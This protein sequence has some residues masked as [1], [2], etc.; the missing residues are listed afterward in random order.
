MD[1]MSCILVAFKIPIYFTGRF[2]SAPSRDLKQ[3]MKFSTVVN[4]VDY[5]K[6]ADDFKVRVKHLPTNTE[7]EEKF[8]H[9]IV[10]SGTFSYG[11]KPYI[12]GIEQ[13]K[14]PV[15]HSQ[16]VKHMEEFKGRRI[17]LIGARWSAE[18]FALQAYKYGAKSVVISWRTAPHGHDWFEFPA[19]ITQHPQVVKFIN[20]KACFKDGFEAEFDMV[21]YCTGYIWNF[22]FMAEDLRLKEQ[23]FGAASKDFYKAT[24]WLNGGNGKVLYFGAPYIIFSFSIFEA[25]AIW[26]RKYIMG[27]LAVPSQEEML[28]DSEKWV[29]KFS[30][31][32][33]SK[34]LNVIEFFA[35]VL[36]DLCIA[37]GYTTKCVKGLEILQDWGR[38][39]AENILT[40]RDQQYRSVFTEKLAPK[41][42]TPWL[43][44]FDDSLKSFGLKPFTSK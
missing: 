14:G 19:M 40:F 4:R 44:A 12:E 15:L 16:D 34:F 11:N 41:H 8:S 5:I 36:E 29:Q 23:F 3:F 42:H 33:F 20:N 31:V 18:D 24:L 35:Q 39:K 27:E 2:T 13:F 21:I 1:V 38:H 32:D 43:G 22:P 10:A 37:S 7:S 30:Q 6:E 25:Q 17:L 9:I 28:E 26:A